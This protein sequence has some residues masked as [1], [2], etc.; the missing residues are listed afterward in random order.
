MRER[1]ADRG[2]SYDAR[3]GAGERETARA[4]SPEEA[5][6]ERSYR[7]RQDVESAATRAGNLSA[8]VQRDEWRVERA[9]LATAHTTLAARL[10]EFAAHTKAS[11]RAQE[12]QVAITAE[13]GELAATLAN[14][15]EPRAT[16]AVSGEE[17]IEPLIVARSAVADDV[18][19]WVAGLGGAERQALAKRVRRVQGATE[20]EDGFAVGL[21]NFLASTRTTSQFFGVVENPRRFNRA[22]Y[23]KARASTTASATAPIPPDERTEL[24]ETL[25][26]TASRAPS[27]LP[28]RAEMERGFG[29]SLG[30]VEAHLGMAAELAPHGAQAIAA[31]NVVAFADAD[32]SPAIVAHEVT[33]VVQNEQA[34]SAAPMASGLVAP[35]DSAAEAEADEIAGQVAVHGP[36]VRLP[37]IAAAP[38]AH[39]HLAPKHLVPDA[40][41]S[42]R[43]STIQVP[44]AEHPSRRGV[45]G[46]Q[47]IQTDKT[48][49]QGHP[50]PLRGK[51]WKSLAEIAESVS[52]EDDSGDTLHIDITYRLESRPAEVGEV[53]EVWIHTERK[54]LLTIGTG[55]HAGAT[56]VG[57]ARV[58]LAPG[59]AR[60]PKAA[61]ARQ[62]IGPDHWAQIYLAEA[63]QYVNLGGAGG[64]GSLLADAAGNDVLA[65]DDPLR[66]LV[67]LKNILKQQHVAGRGGDVAKMHARAQRMLAEAK[68][69]RVV[70]EREIA[71]VTSYHDPQPGMVAPVRFLVGDMAEWLAANQQAGR[72]ATE[73]ADQ[74]RKTR[75]ELEHLIGDAEHARPP[76]RDQLDDAL[77]APIR[78][79]ERTAEGAVE[80]A[81]M[82][83]DAAVLGVDAVGQW[84][85]IGTFDYHPIS[86]YG[87]SIDE[88]GAKTTTA[89]I[90]MVNGFADEWAD[91]IERAK[92]GDYRSLTDVSVDTLMMIDGARTS[93]TIALQKGEALAV[94]LG[95]IA[96]SARAI[97]SGMPAEGRAIAAAM[98]DGADAF[99]SRLRAGGMQMAGADGGGPASTFGGL[100]AEVLAEAAQAAKEAFR[101]RG[102]A[103]P[104]EALA[105]EHGAHG[106][107]PST[108]HGTS[109]PQPNGSI[110]HAPSS[111]IDPAT[112]W[113]SETAAKLSGSTARNFRKVTANKPAS[114]VLGH[115]RELGIEQADLQRLSALLEDSYVSNLSATMRPRYERFLEEVFAGKIRASDA[116]QHLTVLEEAKALRTHLQSTVTGDAGNRLNIGQ[117]NIAHGSFDIKLPNGKV[118]TDK[119]VSVS[120]KGTSR[121]ITEATGAKVD[122]LTV[123][124]E[125]SKADQG[126]KANRVARRPRLRAQDL[127]E[128]PRPAPERL[129]H[130]ARGWHIVQRQRLLRNNQYS[131]RDAAV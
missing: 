66:T 104:A 78:V 105:H 67:G 109:G 29:R 94:K 116:R 107:A 91:A 42:P 83:V 32:P 19:A 28:Y 77:S 39:V 34:G 13:L 46:E 90:T 45:D 64:R 26:G 76:K 56:I 9:S 54:A 115:F 41:S 124:P 103:Q 93:G 55:E 80:I 15:K 131:H 12:H 126:D 22:A 87:R 58:H 70:L 88:T 73:D 3:H 65:Y 128:Y 98:A 69:A 53:P 8:V 120:G 110:P 31:R 101:K 127:R 71:S 111:T 1:R 122:G 43:R 86:K 96:R 108:E 102:A 48:V 61:I 51:S 106:D 74:L 57:Q 40:D 14:A 25:G 5:A 2:S 27:E 99:V 119:L 11:G 38:A 21:A 63:Q 44:D 59:E 118:I 50:T 112:Q 130:E 10:E 30:H 129:G 84:T 121:A 49:G 123:A 16:P 36:G 72:D 18:L 89:L 117:R 81:A 68:R 24:D 113:V 20:R 33:H 47:V 17:A 23:E 95:S 35:R 60:D 7:L 79:A 6:T 4:R 97:V 37:P 100:S 114:D 52:V 62:S 75:A 82:A 85:G 125:I 92:H